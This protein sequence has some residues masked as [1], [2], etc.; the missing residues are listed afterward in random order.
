MSLVLPL[1]LAAA[2]GSASAPPLYLTEAP[3]DTAVSLD[4]R[5]DEE[6]WQSLPASTDFVVVQPDTL[7]PPPLRTSVRFFYTDRGIY[8]GADMEQPVDTLVERLSP[9]DQGYLNR[10]AFTFNLDTSGEGRYGFWFQVALGGSKSD[11]T[12][13]PERDYSDTWDGAWRAATARTGTGWSAELFVPWSVVSMPR[14]EGERR[15][16]FFGQRSVAYLSERWGWPAL[17]WSRPKFISD[18]QPLALAPGVD[19]RHE[20]SVVPYASS[21]YD[22]LGDSVS[23]KAGMDM[24]WRPSTNFRMNA[25]LNPDFGNVEAD[26]VIVNLSAFETFF[27]EKRLFFQED[28]E[29][30]VT[31]PRASPFRRSSTPPFLL[32]HTRRIGAPPERPTLSDGRLAE[33]A[34]FARPTELLGAA[35]VSGQYGGMRYGVLAAME[36]ETVFT[37]TDPAG[38]RARLR[39]DGRDFEAVRLLYER[40]EGPYRAIGWMSTHADRL[41][42]E[43]TVQALDGH[44][45]SG[46]GSWRADGQWVSSDVPDGRGYGGFVDLVWAPRQGLSHSLSV[47]HF[48]PNL[49]LNDLGYLYRNDLTEY[50][51]RWRTQ[52]SDLGWVRD[53]WSSVGFHWGRNQRGERVASGIGVFQQYRLHGLSEVTIRGGF[54]PAGFDDRSAFGAG[55]FR[56]EDRWDLGLSFESDSARRFF[57]EV[58]IEWEDEPLEGGK[59]TYKGELTWR[60]TDRLTLEASLDYVDRDGWLLYRGAGRMAAFE[61][62][63]WI[64]GWNVD[65]FLSARQQFR[66]AFQWVGVH[67]R[68]RA[69]Y[70]IP[71]RPGGLL[72]EPGGDDH[73]AFTISELA[74]QVRYRWELAP[75]SDLFV[76][77]TRHASLPSAVGEGFTGLF[78]NALDDP[79]AEQLVV[80]VRYRLGT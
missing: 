1:V 50:R 31:S 62:E 17:P 47:D 48:D 51:Y 71:D 61:A 68:D 18:F 67:A 57:Y 2:V 27:P 70:R 15:L 63:Q 36:D 34:A 14:T 38:R 80:K 24:R 65:Y 16:G 78:S 7:Q 30:F 46:D 29:I 23:G 44:F 74:L 41:A 20:Y 76:V 42:G 58:G 28:Q 21:T 4:G 52:R 49:E 77:Y 22:R 66:V 45:Q 56:V 26:D 37:A 9:R 72:P 79:I 64:P 12:L 10:D 33:E 11:G 75:M 53:R 32:L 13:L 8:I 40:S 55:S 6:V 25:T 19:P 35:K 43:A 3:R 69:S 60:P 59:A 5:L 54:S 73:D 39:Q